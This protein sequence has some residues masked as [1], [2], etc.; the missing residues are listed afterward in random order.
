M[1]VLRF[2]HSFIQPRKGTRIYSS[3]SVSARGRQEAPWVGQPQPKSAALPLSPAAAAKS[4][5]LLRLSM[6]SRVESS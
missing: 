4:S 1:N 6:Q 5:N 2:T 3:V